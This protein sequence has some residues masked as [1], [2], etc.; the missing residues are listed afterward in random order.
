MRHP[1]TTGILLIALLNI[2]S[3]YSIHFVTYNVM[4]NEKMPNGAIPGD[5][6]ER[7]LFL[8]G[9][10]G[11]QHDIYVVSLQEN[12]YNCNKA[13]LPKVADIFS[14]RL[15]SINET[16]KFV[17]LAATRKSQWCESIYCSSLNNQHGTSLIMIF[18]KGDIVKQFRVKKRNAC[19]VAIMFLK[20]E[21]KGLAGLQLHMKDGKILCFIGGHLDPETWENRQKCIKNFFVKGKES[22][23]HGQIIEQTNWLQTCDSIFIGGDFN[24]RTGKKENEHKTADRVGQYATLELF[25]S[26]IER[27]ELSGENPYNGKSMLKYI[28]EFT[29]RDFKEPQR[30]IVDNVNFKATYSLISSDYCSNSFP[31]YTA[32]RP[33]SW[34]D[35]IICDKCG[36]VLYYSSL[37]DVNG[38]SDHLPVVGIFQDV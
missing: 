24:T 31:C 6:A 13:N 12:C 8:T 9:E 38:F 34:T 19:S 28:R 14:Q 23:E 33:I 3:P 5:L 7:L 35:R 17:G 10:D 16:Y 21:E 4:N 26:L 18:T 25:Q 15:Q 32:K 1:L 37:L 22:N 27:D 20:N 36:R 29:G 11:T 30:P 2:V